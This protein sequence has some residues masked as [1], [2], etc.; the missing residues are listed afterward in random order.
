MAK[1]TSFTNRFQLSVAGICS[2]KTVKPQSDTLLV[3]IGFAIN[4]SIDTRS[5]FIDPNKT[6]TT[7]FTVGRGHIVTATG[8]HFVR[9][10]QTDPAIAN[11]K[12][13]VPE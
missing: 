10:K 1:L 3:R 8:G 5:R 2:P 6:P 4:E 9:T 13:A 12:T 11:V 7:T